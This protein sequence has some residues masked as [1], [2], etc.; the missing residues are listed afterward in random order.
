MKKIFF[1]SLN[2]VVFFC[3]QPLQAARLSFRHGIAIEEDWIYLNGKKFFINAV[4][5]AGWRPGQ[6]PGTDK[7][8]LRL[9]ELDFQRIKEAG[10]NTVRTWDALSPEELD[11]A[12]KYGLKV[13]QGI[14]LDPSRDFS[15]RVFIENAIRY[16][17]QV[18]EWSKGHDNILMYLVMTEP[19]QEAVLYAG[20][21]STIK[22]FQNIKNIIQSIDHKPVS[23]DSW[24]AIAFLDHSF[25]DIVTFNVFKF[26]PESINQTVGFRN[27]VAWIKARYAA[28]KPLFVGET[29]GFSI[30][31]KRLNNIGFGGNSLEEQ[32]KGDIESIQESIKAKAAGVCTVSWIDTW[33]YP[34]DP[35]THD[36]HPWEWDGL[37][38]FENIDDRAG[39]PRRVYDQ[40]RLFNK[41]LVIDPM[42]EK[43]NAPEE[44]SITIKENFEKKD[45]IHLTVKFRMRGKPIRNQ[46]IKA[47][48]LWPVEWEEKILNTRTDKDGSAEVEFPLNKESKSR[49]VV[50]SIGF[51]QDSK[52]Y[53]DIK[54]I[55]LPYARAMGNNKDKFFIYQDK[56]YP[57]NHYYPS[58][59]VGD[60]K[61][62]SFDDEYSVYPHSGKTC[63]KISYLDSFKTPL[64]QGWAGIYWQNPLNNWFQ[65]EGGVDLSGYKKLTFWARASREGVGVAE[66]GVGGELPNTDQVRFGPVTLIK[67]WQQF[68]INLE[69]KNLHSIIHG[70][71]IFLRRDLN[72]D[73]Y[74]IFLDDIVFER[75][76]R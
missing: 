70:F 7:V 39:T 76:D 26:V 51:Q 41:N 4:G 15:D 54:I 36:D 23:M 37:I 61:S 24:I 32:A 28:Y 60:Y 1:I 22:F 2:I 27:Y 18:V 14:W 63:I 16:I 45:V 48:I 44:T 29:G 19:R 69:A 74:T 68:T 30:S 46:R 20:E 66:F 40:I 10:F 72:E 71:R 52:K 62:L 9:V 49:Y 50:V 43:V 73:G 34:K 31:K 65:S 47:G 17:K 58:G 11:L 35:Q 57:G 33:H 25:W 59:W 56:H 13:I 3:V 75:G 8:D 53:G 21:E 55:R 42:M 5:Y 67:K 38:G 64:G 6:W 12:K